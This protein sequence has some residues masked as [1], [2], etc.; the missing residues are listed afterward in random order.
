MSANLSRSALRLL[1]YLPAIY[2]DEPFVG[3]YLWAFEQ[4]LEGLEDQIAQLS[5]LFDPLALPED[6]ENFLPWLSS[7][8]AF[9][10]RAD[11]DVSQQRAF[12]AQVVPLYRRRGTKENLHNLLSIFTVGGVTITEDEPDRPHYFKVTIRLPRAAADVQLRQQAIAYALVDLEKPAHTYY[13]L[14]VQFP[15]MQIG[16]TSTIG[17][18]TL[19]GTDGDAAIGAPAAAVAPT[20]LK[21]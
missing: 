15:S 10:L 5:Q 9:T 6:R 19:L 8:V 16:V 2:R 18:D 3:R 4:V 20:A 12:L 14:D 17:V 21:P 1:S 7:W 13:D 11:L